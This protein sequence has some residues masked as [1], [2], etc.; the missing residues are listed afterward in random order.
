V[1]LPGLYLAVLELVG[2]VLQ[3]VVGSTCC[4]GQEGR[5]ESLYW[6][7]AVEILLWQGDFDG[8]CLVLIGTGL[9]VPVRGIDTK[10]CSGGRPRIGNAQ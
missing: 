1:G 4:F 8:Q 3:L 9:I 10:G 5:S 6:L 7:P 2:V